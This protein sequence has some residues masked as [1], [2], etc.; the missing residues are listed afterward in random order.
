[1]ASVN[2]PA[3]IALMVTE[4]ASS[5]ANNVQTEIVRR[6]V[7]R[8]E[9]GVALL[10]QM[11]IADVA[12]GGVG[13]GVSI[14]GFAVMNRKLD[15]IAGRLGGIEDGLS[16]ISA[17]LDA[18]RAE[19]ERATIAKLRNLAAMFEDSWEMTNSNRA[20]RNWNRIYEEG[21]D[22]EEH[23][24]DRAKAERD[25]A[26]PSAAT[27]PA[28]EAQLDA[29]ALVSGLRISAQLALGEVENARTLERRSAADLRG[30]TST[31]GLADLVL[32][33]LSDTA[34]GSVEWDL[35]RAERVSELRPV[36]A[37]LRQ[38]EALLATR[39]AFL[40][41]LARHGATPREWLRLIREE[42]QTA[43]LVLEDR[44]E[45]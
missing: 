10:Q 11:G 17:K 15:S 26:A 31:I 7:A 29:F 8:V 13:L 34:P 6:G 35:A 22:L 25:I 24:I 40:P 32:P 30:V 36:V 44:R 3:A 9:N 39:T 4:V 41:L 37:R 1:M 38:R 2:P 19:Q 21:G 16:Q 27:L 14:A 12:L 42:T 20:E 28:V 33:A 43:V 23:F 5:L 18:V 45:G